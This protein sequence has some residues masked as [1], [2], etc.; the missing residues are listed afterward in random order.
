MIK[1]PKLLLIA[2]ILLLVASGFAVKRLNFLRTAKRTHGSV[3]SVT[4]SNGSCSDG[5]G[6]SRRNYSCTTFTAQ[7]RFATKTGELGMLELDAG[8][9]A[10]HNE[11]TSGA[12]RQVGAS[13]PV[14]YNPKNLHEAYENTTFGV[15]GAPL[16]SGGGSLA[17]L[18]GSF[19]ER[20]RRTWT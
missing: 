6:K 9:R 14:V 11:P 15:W 13:V 18:M 10:G 3:E 16:A 2:G 12:S 20:R 8:S 1:Q 4:A 17:T 5:S 7:V 19:T